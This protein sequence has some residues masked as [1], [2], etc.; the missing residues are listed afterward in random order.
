MNVGWKERFFFYWGKNKNSKKS[1]LNNWLM[2]GCVSSSS[3]YC[4]GVIG[5][6][7]NG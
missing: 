4:G 7:D 2:I 3:G 5:S 1:W 6:K